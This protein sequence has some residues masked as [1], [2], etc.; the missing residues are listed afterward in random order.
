MLNSSD[1]KSN[2]QFNIACIIC[3]HFCKNISPYVCLSY[4]LIHSFPLL[5]FS[6]PNS[7][8][9]FTEVSISATPHPPQANRPPMCF[10]VLWTQLQ[11]WGGMTGPRLTPFLLI[12]GSSGQNQPECGTFLTQN[13]HGLVI[14]LDRSLP[15]DFWENCLTHHRR[16]PLLLRA[17]WWEGAKPGAAAAIFTIHEARLRLMPPR[18]KRQLQTN[19]AGSDHCVFGCQL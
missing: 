14:Q 18:R 11:F 4:N 17:W 3:T 6:L 13:L 10:R 1:I 2:I 8:L 19:E 12:L 7:T 5:F 16:H 15:G 9:I